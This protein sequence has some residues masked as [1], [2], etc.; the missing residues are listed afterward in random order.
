MKGVKQ[1][2]KR[3]RAERQAET[4]C[5]GAQSVAQHSADETLKMSN[6]L[7]LTLPDHLPTFAN[8][9]WQKAAEESGSRVIKGDIL[10]FKDGKWFSGKSPMPLI[11]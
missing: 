3:R 2:S 9:G 8:D 7:T 5:C 1:M 6:E 4:Q 11:L 10:R